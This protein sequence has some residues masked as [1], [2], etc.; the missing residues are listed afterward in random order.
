MCLM[1]S[2]KEERREFTILLSAKRHLTN[3]RMGRMRG[4]LQLSLGCHFHTPYQCW[5]F[6]VMY[7]ASH[8]GAHKNYY[9][10]D[11]WVCTSNRCDEE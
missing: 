5:N 2:I 7:V 8:H 3:V 9:K 6:S 10:I 1:A 11:L 4:T